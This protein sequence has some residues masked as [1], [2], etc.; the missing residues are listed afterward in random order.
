[1]GEMDALEI[2]R[3]VKSGAGPES[4]YGTADLAREMAGEHERVAQKVQ[5]L[6]AAM[7]SHWEGPAAGQAHAGAGP[8]VQASD[9]SAGHLAEAQNLLTGQGSSFTDLKNKIGDGPGPPP[10][11]TFLSDNL[12]F[13]TSRDEEIEA[14]NA[15]AQQVVDN[16]H[17]YHG[18]STH[19]S[20]RWPTDYGQLGLPPGGGDIDVRTPGTG[21][22][23]HTT[24]PPAVGGG[25]G[26]STRVA[27]HTGGPVHTAAPS[28]TV[29]QPGPAP[30]PGPG[31]QPVPPGL[32]PAASTH[33]A[34][35]GTTPSRTPGDTRTGT[36]HTPTTDLPRTRHGAGDLG[37]PGLLP[38]RSG[39]PAPGVPGSGG[40]RAGWNPGTA[41]PRVAGGT[42]GGAPGNN[43]GGGPNLGQGKGVGSA[44]PG[45]GGVARG[46]PAAAAAPATGRPGAGMA[47]MA[48]AAGRG[49]GGEDTEHQRPDYLQ[50]PDP[51]ALFGPAD[52]T[53]PPVIGE[54]RPD[55]ER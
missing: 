17:L 49:R 50:E 53:T 13:L 14:W 23:V 51:D 11:E 40:G 44:P 2:V 30:Q 3:R 36:G 4:L 18:Q 42:T 46:G 54:H 52:R 43:P 55:S 39:G 47:P 34:S 48:G 31:S 41:G 9:V 45:Q 19:N 28:P 26:D 7:E 22:G 24:A 15:R 38:G 5:R 27:G 8:L 25:V 29:G 16:Y 35:T 33:T 6:R 12:P 10:G 21:G 1:M 32:A 37:T 20:A